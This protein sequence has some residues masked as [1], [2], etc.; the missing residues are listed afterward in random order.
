M[1]DKIH[2]KLKN[3]KIKNRICSKNCKRF[4]QTNCFSPINNFTYSDRMVEVSHKVDPSINSV[5]NE[6]NTYWVLNSGPT[7]QR[8]REKDDK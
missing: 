6:H 7:T 8:G 1:Y 2:Y 5:E 4:G 3:K